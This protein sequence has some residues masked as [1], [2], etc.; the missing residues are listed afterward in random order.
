MVIPAERIVIAG[1]S[2]AGLAT[3]T[4]L[5]ENGFQ[6]SL[7]LIGAEADLPYDRPPLSKTL[8]PDPAHIALA[9]MAELDR[10]D[11]DLKLGIRATGLN[12]EDR[13]LELQT[14]NSIAW[15]RCVIA[16]GVEPIS[17][18]PDSV[19]LRTLS[20]ARRI[21]RYLETARHVVIVGAGVLGCELAAL[22]RMNGVEATVIDPLDGPMLDKVGPAVSARLLALHTENGVRFRFGQRVSNIQGDSDTGYALTLTDSSRLEADHVFLAIG[23]RPSTA[24]LI[25]SSVPLDNGVRCNSY[26]ESLP[27]IFA[28]GDVA[29]WYNPRFGRYM[30]IEHRMNA[31]EQGIAVAENIL[32][33]GAPFAPIPFFWTDHYAAKVQVHGLIGADSDVTPLAGDPETGNFMMAYSRNGLIEG[34]LGWNMAK[35]LRGARPLIGQLIDAMKDFAA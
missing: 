23:C 25:G 1:A 28:A 15:D 27:G 34:V 33:E 20:D 32:D 13:T 30:R 5:R 2:A 17:L 14:G 9:G 19:I 6:G 3:A 24:W 10:L 16:T 21:S 7:T 22:A 31:T 29:N 11:I 12:Y 8:N 35:A 4:A 26:C 18:G